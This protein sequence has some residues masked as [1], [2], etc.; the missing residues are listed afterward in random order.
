M[1]ALALCSDK[2]RYL[3]IPHW[4]RLEY[5]CF[6]PS[7]PVFGVRLEAREHRAKLKSLSVRG[8][9]FEADEF[10]PHSTCV[11][12]RVTLQDDSVPF[13]FDCRIVRSRKVEDE[14]PYRVTAD[15]IAS[16]KEEI[17]RI[18]RFVSEYY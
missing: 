17:D 15:F 14:H 1:E 5:R 3:R 18:N 11:M 10:L 9:F 2:V 8:I 4:V 13:E 7:S 12:I 16:E 6:H